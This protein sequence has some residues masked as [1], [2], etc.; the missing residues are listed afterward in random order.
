MY[1]CHLVFSIEA[2]KS[3]LACMR[4]DEPVFLFFEADISKIKKSL[5]LSH[6][7]ILSLSDKEHF[8]KSLS[9]HLAKSECRCVSYY[10]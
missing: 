1:I 6:I 4:N 7:S 3:N 10:G 2:L 5:S 9:E 8:T